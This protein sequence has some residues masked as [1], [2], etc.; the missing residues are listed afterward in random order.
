MIEVLNLGAGV[1]STTVLLMSL[2]GELPPLDYVLFADTGW[3][4]RAV[5]LHLEWLETLTKIHVLSAGN[6]RDDHT[7]PQTKRQGLRSTIP[8]YVDT[9]GERE[10]RTFRK[11]TSEYKIVPCNKFI[12]REVLGLKKGQRAPVPPTVRR[13]YGISSD[14]A[15]RCRTSP[16]KWATNYYPLVEMRRSRQWCLNWLRE[17][18]YEEPQRSACLGCPFHSNAEWRNLSIID[19]KGFADA[20]DFDEVC[21]DHSALS[22]RAYLHRS[23]KPLGEIDF[24]NDVDRGQQLLWQDECSGMCGV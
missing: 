23:L 20:V 14:E 24:R 22:G 13:W 2:A 10:G 1:Q 21:R 16:E 8:F 5:Y 4:P 12:R 9:G 17:N 3:E 7:N 15:Q 6:I 19:P 11:C 18:G